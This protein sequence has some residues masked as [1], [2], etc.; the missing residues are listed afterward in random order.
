M[1]E[2]DA[3]TL[4]SLTI[5]PKPHLAEVAGDIAE[6]L[7]TFMMIVRPYVA[8]GMSAPA[9]V[10]AYRAGEAALARAAGR[11]LTSSGER[12]ETLPLPDPDTTPFPA[13]PVSA[14]EGRTV[15]TSARGHQPE[16]ST[17]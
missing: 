13:A 10:E 2:A 12:P 9:M 7:T 11:R 16:A 15:E 3:N 4:I 8:C 17:P 14:P 5:A 6:A 1:S